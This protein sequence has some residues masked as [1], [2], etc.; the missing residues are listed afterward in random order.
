MQ[1]NTYAPSRDKIVRVGA[2]VRPDSALAEIQTLS[3]QLVN[4]ESLGP[5][6]VREVGLMGEVRVHW[7]G[8]NLDTWVQWQDL[9]QIGESARLLTVR[10]YDRLGRTKSTR[11]KVVKAAGLRY[12]WHI[13]IR[14]RNILRA[15][16]TDGQ[17]WTFEW[18]P[19][20]Q[21][22]NPIHTILMD[23][24]QLNDDEAEALTVAEIAATT[25]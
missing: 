4:T 19:L 21:Q 25:K 20:F 18:Y 11:H 22:A 1:M 17:V 13:E 10:V 7:V 15:I 8:A 23:Y 9:D 12:N 5:G 3:G 6:V 16:R 2:L 24:S 14:P